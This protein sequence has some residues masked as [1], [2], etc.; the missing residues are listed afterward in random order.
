MCGALPPTLERLMW[1]Q[2]CGKPGLKLPGF[3]VVLQR[4]QLL[5]WHLAAVLLCCFAATS[6]C[7]F[8]A[9][10]LLCCFIDDSGYQNIDILV[11]L[12]P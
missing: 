1:C 12:A 3:R 6:L 11:S 8:A 7:C 10:L 9:L 4:A 5:A 2:G